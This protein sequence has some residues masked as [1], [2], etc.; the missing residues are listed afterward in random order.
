[1]IEFEFL[2]PK[3]H[4]FLISVSI[5]VSSFVYVQFLFVTSFAIFMYWKPPQTP[6]MKSQTHKEELQQRIRLTMDSRKLRGVRGGSFT[7]AKPLS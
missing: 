7:H 5:V 4:F 2:K 1:M 6:H 3:V